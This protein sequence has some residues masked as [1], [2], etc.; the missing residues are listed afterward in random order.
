MPDIIRRKKAFSLCLD[1][2]FPPRCPVCHGIAPWGKEICPEC[3]KKLPYVTGK[4]CRK[5]GKPVEPYETLCDDCRRMSHFYDEGIGLFL[6][7]ETMRE[8]MAYLKYKGRKEYGRALGELLADA[9]PDLIHRWNPD[10]I[11]PVP[12][13]PDRL[14]ERGYNQAEEIAKPLAARY[15]LPVRNDLVVRQGKTV[16]MK[17]LS[18]EERMENMRRAFSVSAEEKVPKKILIIDD[19]YTTG[20]TVDA[21]SQL[22]LERGAVHVWFLT[23]CIGMGFMV[24]Y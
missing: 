7:D 13:H 12:V 9:V 22:L 8:T 11:V 20:A 24:R 14:R 23:V 16:A 2:L 15:C 4:R 1:L 19:I 5:C 3:V 18:R 6:Y 21:M 10:V 17:K